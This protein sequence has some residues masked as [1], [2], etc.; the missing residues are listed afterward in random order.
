[1]INIVRDNLLTREGYAPYC[2]DGNCRFHMPRTAFDGEQF[3][4]ICGWRSGFPA[5]FIA[6]YKAKWNLPEGRS[7]LSAEGRGR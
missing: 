7:A 5:D 3:R 4:C 1:M 2:G 6:E